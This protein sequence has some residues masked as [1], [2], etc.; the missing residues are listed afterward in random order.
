MELRSCAYVDAANDPVVVG[1]HGWLHRDGLLWC[2]VL[3][4]L[5]GEVPGAGR[6]GTGPGRTPRLLQVQNPGDRLRGRPA[7][8]DSG[9]PSSEHSR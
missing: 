1:S 6:T 7:R 9:C 4:H 5:I 3:R 2:A 8:A